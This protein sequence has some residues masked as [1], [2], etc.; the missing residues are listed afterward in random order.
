[1]QIKSRPP[2]L[3][4]YFILILWILQQS[5]RMFLSSSFV[6]HA[7]VALKLSAVFCPISL[8]LLHFDCWE[9]SC[10][11]YLCLVAPICL[12]WVL[13][14]ISSGWYYGIDSICDHF[15]LKYLP[16]ISSVVFSV[17]FR[18]FRRVT[19]RN[20]EL[21]QKSGWVRLKSYWV[22]QKSAELDKDFSTVN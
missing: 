11:K 12:Q 1:M 19:R 7:Y 13:N 21:D 15:P 2:G 4:F 10:E 18:R 14:L 5:R 9:A 16:H 22:R 3:S 6:L 17:F 20:S 8:A